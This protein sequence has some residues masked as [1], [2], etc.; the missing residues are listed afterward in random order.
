MSVMCL[1]CVLFHGSLYHEIILSCLYTST[2]TCHKNGMQLTLM[3]T[4]NV[5][6]YT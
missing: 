1:V 2:Y 4:S 6:V 5:H 3:H